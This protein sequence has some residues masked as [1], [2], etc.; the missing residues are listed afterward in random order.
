MSW[1]YLL[2]KFHACLPTYKETCHSSLQVFFNRYK[3]PENRKDHYLQY[4]LLSFHS[5]I[6]KKVKQKICPLSACFWVQIGQ[7]VGNGLL[8]WLCFWIRFS[9]VQSIWQL[10]AMGSK[11]VNFETFFLGHIWDIKFSNQLGSEKV[12]AKKQWQSMARWLY[13]LANQFP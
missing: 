2:P 9:K 5:P 7:Q 6:L 12:I 8:R 10:P 4:L 3:N 13:K 11:M 1:S